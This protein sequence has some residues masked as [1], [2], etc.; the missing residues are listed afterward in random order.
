LF[1]DGANEIKIEKP[2]GIFLFG[3][4]PNPVK[5]YLAQVKMLQIIAYY[6]SVGFVPRSVPVPCSS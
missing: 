3:L 6:L 5:N 4:S 2:T 1:Y